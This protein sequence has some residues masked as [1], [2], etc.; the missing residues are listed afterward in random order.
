MKKLT[1]ALL[2]TG[3]TLALAAC[4]SAEDASSEATADTV[5]MPS[6]EALEGVTDE[7]VEDADAM[8]E[9][10]PADTAVDEQTATAAA[11][12]AADVAAQ[13]EAVAAEAEGAANAVGDAVDAAEDAIN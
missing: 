3:A 12:A 5:E 2:V 8:E 9:V 4:G 6:D 11:D 13:V 10:D 7:P 1:S